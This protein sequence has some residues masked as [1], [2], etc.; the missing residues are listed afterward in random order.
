MQALLVPALTLAIEG[1]RFLF[2][3]PIMGSRG[4][5]DRRPVLLLYLFSVQIVSDW[6]PPDLNTGLPPFLVS[7]L[8]PYIHSLTFV[9][10]PSTF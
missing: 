4:M 6:P 1:E 3:V 9:S 8:P 2:P 5:A 7:F 10:T